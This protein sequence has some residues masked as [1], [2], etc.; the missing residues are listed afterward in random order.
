MLCTSCNRERRL[1]GLNNITIWIVALLFPSKS[2]LWL[3]NNVAFF[4]HLP[5]N[6]RNY[7]LSD[8]IGAMNI[9]YRRR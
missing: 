6:P 9:F 7:N 5:V 1:T 4:Y 8:T 2:T 3:L